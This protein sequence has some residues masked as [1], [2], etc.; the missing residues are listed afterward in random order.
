MKPRHVIGVGLGLFVL[1]SCGCGSSDGLN[2]GSDL[3]GR[4]TLDGKP[5]GG[6]RVELWSLDGLN[7]VSCQLRN[8][9][10]YT[11][12][13]P[14]LGPCKVVVMTSH[15]KGVPAAPRR[16]N[17]RAGQP[18]S[19]GMT[20]PDGLGLA[21]TPIPRRY[22]DLATTDLTLTVERG[23]HTQDITLTARR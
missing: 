9:G 21:Y 10:T 3:S 16:L 15:L 12:A 13:E 6:G 2:R 8:D 19:A 5:L 1:F 17:E 7:S 22:E 23:N 4:V 11:V 18:G 14:P 20:S